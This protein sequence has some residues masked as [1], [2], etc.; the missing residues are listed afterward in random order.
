MFLSMR[1][2]DAK[3]RNWVCCK[4]MCSASTTIEFWP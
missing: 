2:G 1:F 4:P 3:T